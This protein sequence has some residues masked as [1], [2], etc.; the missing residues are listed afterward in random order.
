[1]SAA[2]SPAPFTLEMAD[3]IEKIAQALAMALGAQLA[4]GALP[5]RSA[6]RAVYDIAWPGKQVASRFTFAIAN[7]RADD[8]NLHPGEIQISVLEGA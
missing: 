5:I 4:D 8:P 7:A 2:S 3:D 1:M 6:Y